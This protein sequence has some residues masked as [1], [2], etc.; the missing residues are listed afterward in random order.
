[1]TRR[2]SLIFESLGDGYLGSLK[3][4]SHQ[5]T[6]IPTLICKQLKIEVARALEKISTQF[7]DNFDKISSTL[8]ISLSAFTYRAH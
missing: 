5:T 6:K 2:G 4:E 3:A 1:M 7:K 8:K